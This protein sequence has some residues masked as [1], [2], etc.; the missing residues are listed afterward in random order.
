L[1]EIDDIPDFLRG[2][3]TPI[4]PRRRRRDKPKR[5]DGERWRAAQLTR[6]YLYDEAP[7]IGCG[8]RLVWVA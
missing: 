8:E 2:P 7:P 4:E 5:P 1:T 6:V 3:R